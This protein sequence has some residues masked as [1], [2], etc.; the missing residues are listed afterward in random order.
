M[1]SYKLYDPITKIIIISWGV[2]LLENEGW[3]GSVEKNK[4]IIDCVSHDD[5][6]DEVV[7][8]PHI[9]QILIPSTPRNAPHGATQTIV[10]PSA[11]QATLLSTPRVQQT[12]MSMYVVVASL[13]L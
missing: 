5:M 12:L 10:P 3:D 6:T 13:L 11:S 4:K 1:Q 8:I 7:N 2:H 9:I